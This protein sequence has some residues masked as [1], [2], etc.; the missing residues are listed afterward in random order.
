MP[1]RPKTTCQ[2]IGCT[3]LGTGGWCDTHRPKPID[4]RPTA[5]ERGYDLSWTRFA[6][7]FMS[8][9]ENRWCRRCKDEHRHAPAEVAD[10]IVPR[11]AGGGHCD[12]ENTQPLC[13][14]CNR[15]KGIEDLERYER[16]D[17]E[18]VIEHVNI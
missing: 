13:R 17:Q 18:R 5:R 4:N 12:V 3:A 14:S 2:H 15:L 7:W 8:L 9:P 11:W 1:S 10:H 16:V 6:R